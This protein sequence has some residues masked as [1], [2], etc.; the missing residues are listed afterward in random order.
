M[1]RSAKRLYPRL[2][3]LISLTY[4]DA[5]ALGPPG[6]VHD[7]SAVFDASSEQVYIDTLHLNEKGNMII[8]DALRSTI[9][10]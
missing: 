1:A 10:P 8:V 9:M 2:D 6:R 5:L 4:G 7:L 3:R